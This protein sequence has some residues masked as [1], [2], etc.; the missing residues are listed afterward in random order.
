L[1]VQTGGGKALA[2]MLF[3]LAHAAHHNANADKSPFRRIIVVIPY[4]SII[5]QTVKELREVFG[6]GIVDEHHSQADEPAPKKSKKE[7]E[8]GL[9]TVRH[10][11][12]QPKRPPILT[13][14]GTE[15]A[16]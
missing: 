12:C 4:L 11:I 15:F 1:T 5:H 13:Y 6:D 8:D 2:S 9:N 7:K 14:L 3:A 10:D 16:P